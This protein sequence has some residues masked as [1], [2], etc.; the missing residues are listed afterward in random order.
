[1]ITNTV[2][3][4]RARLY[5]G[6]AITAGQVPYLAGPP[7]IG[8]SAIAKNMA[9][10]IN[11][12]LI[13]YRFSTGTPEDQTGLPVKTIQ[14]GKERAVF[15]PFND[16]FPTEDTP[17]PPGKDG[18]LLFLDELSNAPKHMQA[19]AYKVILDRMVGDKRLHPN[20]VLMA[21]GN[22]IEDRAAAVQLGSAL[23]SRMIMLEVFPELQ[24]WLEDVA[25]PNRYDPRIVAFLS[26]YPEMLMNFD[27]AR[28][29]GTFACPRTWSFMDSILKVDG[30]DVVDEHLALF[31]GT[32]GATAAPQFLN[33]ITVFTRLP[34]L[35]EIVD[36]PLTAPI[37][38]DSATNWAIASMLLDKVTQDNANALLTYASRLPATFMIF[39]GKAAR[40]QNPWL[41]TTTAWPAFAGELAQRMIPR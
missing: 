13:D 41:D 38:T 34:S 20:V 40:L 28:D 1:M 11:Y 22:R 8:K 30:V 27:P 19:A 31:S 4:R 14:N 36:K 9:D 6:I 10:E 5:A 29:R 26:N 35:A 39:F 25:L 12:Q 33:F 7:G 24:E 17:L 32:V 3:L 16:L 21:A 37:G 23:N 18:W 15:L 2:S